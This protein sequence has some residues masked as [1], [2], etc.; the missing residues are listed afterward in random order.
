V[1]RGSSQRAVSKADAAA[2]LVKSQNWLDASRESLAA[3]RW[4][5]AAGRH[6]AS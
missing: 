5:V 2:Y 3:E 6:L 1:P 4:D